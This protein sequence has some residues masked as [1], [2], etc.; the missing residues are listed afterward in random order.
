MNLYKAAC[1]DIPPPKI[2]VQKS[3]ETPLKV[4]KQ[5]MVPK[6][7]CSARCWPGRVSGPTEQKLLEKFLLMHGLSIQQTVKAATGMI[8][9]YFRLIPTD[10]VHILKCVHVNK[11]VRV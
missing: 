7:C 2:S 8:Y 6:V 9:R 10:A 1:A 3:S 11:L 4:N 5:S